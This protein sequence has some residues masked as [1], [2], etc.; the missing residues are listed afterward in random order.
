MTSASKRDLPELSAAELEFEE[1][2]A[3]L[4]SRELSADQKARLT[5]LVNNSKEYRRRYR[6]YVALHKF[7]RKVNKGALQKAFLAGAQNAAPP[8]D[9]SPAK[10][11][12][13]DL[14]VIPL[15]RKAWFQT[16]VALA[17]S[18]L[19]VITVLLFGNV[20]PE[21]EPTTPETRLLSF[22]HRNCSGAGGQ[23]LKA[24]DALGD[25]LSSGADSFCDAQI[26][27]GGAR[28]AVRLM[29]ES[30]IDMER[31]EGELY[32]HLRKGQLFLDANKQ[33]D[34]AVHVRSGPHMVTVLGTRFMVRRPDSNTIQ[35]DLL[36]G[37]AQVKS[38]AWLRLEY[39]KGDLPADQA[40]ALEKEMPGL[41]QAELQ[42]IEDS[43]SIT[44]RQDPLIARAQA[45]ELAR[46]NQALKQERD[47]GLARKLAAG[48]AE[49]QTGLFHRLAQSLTNQTGQTDWLKEVPFKSDSR[50]LSTRDRLLLERR[51]RGLNIIPATELESPGQIK[52]IQQ[53]IGELDIKAILEEQ[54]K[55]KLPEL[56]YRIHLKDGQVLTGMVVQQGGQYRLLTAKG[57]VLVPRSQVENLEIVFE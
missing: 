11:K 31:I 3:A 45:L 5:L 10:D 30:R 4:L 36:E 18:V 55:Q 8:A 29:P 1:L 37:K 25:S 6:E 9:L 2:M 40:A 56:V 28:V 22:P 47:Q 34:Q 20:L 26:D 50:E 43:R 53:K 16:S 39:L 7:L 57:D 19:I 24:G 17:A 49:M 32:L 35:L 41:F 21:A 54:S 33:A 52:A 51:L 38:A 14:A 15:Y 48:S 12:A 42:V 44:V 13:S 46:L 23:G 27:S